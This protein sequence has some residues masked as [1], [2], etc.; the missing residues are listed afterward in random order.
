MDTCKVV[1]ILEIVIVVNGDVFP[2]VFGKERQ[3]S[4]RIHWGHSWLVEMKVV[5]PFVEQCSEYFVFL[6]KEC[7]FSHNY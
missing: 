2:I 3:Q 1:F 7:G 6:H 5:H 4:L